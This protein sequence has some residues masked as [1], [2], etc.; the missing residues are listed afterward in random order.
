MRRILGLTS[1]W[2]CL[3]GLAAVVVPQPAAAAT[4]YQNVRIGSWHCPSGGTVVAV[5]G[6]TNYP[7]GWTTPG[8]VNGD[9]VR[10]TAWTGSNSA[11]AAITCRVPAWYGARNVHMEI[12]TLMSY[13]ADG[14][15]TKN[16]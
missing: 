7:N 11:N 15:G 2:A 8:P 13:W 5:L 4:V 16:L 9:T 10:V 12:T 1:V 14:S 6:L 3:A